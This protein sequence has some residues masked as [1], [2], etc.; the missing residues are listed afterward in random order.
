MSSKGLLSWC[1]DNKTG[2]CK[3]ERDGFGN[4][5]I[6]LTLQWKRDVKHRKFLCQLLLQHQLAFELNPHKSYR[7]AV[8]I[9]D[10]RGHLIWKSF[11][12]CKDVIF[13]S[14]SGERQFCKIY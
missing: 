11:E 9:P 1:K 12:K 10:G 4:G 5:D 6:V 3:S 8:G 2:T 14:L 13:D 7:L